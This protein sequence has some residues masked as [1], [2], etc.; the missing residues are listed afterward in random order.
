MKPKGRFNMD[1]SKRTANGVIGQKGPMCGSE[2]EGF[3]EG[4]W[5][6]HGF[7][8]HPKTVIG[9]QAIHWKPAQWRVEIEC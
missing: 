8:A 5:I 7:A 2:Q 6:E 9:R 3:V 1:G 4:F